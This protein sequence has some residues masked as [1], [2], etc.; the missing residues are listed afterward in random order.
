MP[1]IPQS[2]PCAAPSFIGIRFYRHVIAG[3]YH[4]PMWDHNE[5]ILAGD[6]LCGS[7]ELMLCA[8][9]ATLPA[10]EQPSSAGQAAI[11]RP[12]AASNCSRGSFRCSMS[13][14]FVLTRGFSLLASSGELLARSS[15][16]FVEQSFSA[17]SHA[18][19]ARPWF[20]ASRRDL[21]A[22]REE[23]LAARREA[24]SAHHEIEDALPEPSVRRRS[25][26]SSTRVRP[27]RPPAPGKTGCRRPPR[28]ALRRCRARFA[29]AGSSG[30]TPARFG[31]P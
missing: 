21:F 28:S 6:G 14:Y 8:P 23:R 17:P 7:R 18:N 27:C 1:G 20:G 3:F 9:Q 31:R 15:R 22:A 25:K 19:I 30:H 24:G 4:P 13:S 11:F 29:A 10:C 26:F 2:Y 16:R 5:L 12:R